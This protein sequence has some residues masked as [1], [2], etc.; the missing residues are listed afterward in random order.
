MRGKAFLSL[1]VRIHRT[2]GCAIMP[3]C[4]L[5]VHNSWNTFYYG[6][7]YQLHESEMANRKSVWKKCFAFCKKL[8]AIAPRNYFSLLKSSVDGHRPDNNE[9]VPTRCVSQNAQFIYTHLYGNHNANLTHQTSFL[10][11]PHYPITDYIK[12]GPTPNLY[13]FPIIYS[14]VDQEIINSHMA[15]KPAEKDTTLVSVIYCF[16]NCSRSNCRA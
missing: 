6:I 2:Y 9:T 1:R 11:Q 16:R 12:W 8:R 3:V 14:K 5:C 15:F 4:M 13:D 7:V 10:S